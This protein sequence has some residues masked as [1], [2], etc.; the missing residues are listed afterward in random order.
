ML[1]PTVSREE[2]VE[3]CREMARQGYAPASG[4]NASIKLQEGVWITAGG[5]VL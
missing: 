1:D 4:G 3:Y 5:S 2:L